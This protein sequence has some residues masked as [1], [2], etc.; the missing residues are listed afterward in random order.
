MKPNHT[1]TWNGKDCDGVRPATGAA[2]AYRCET[3][4]KLCHGKQP[5]YGASLSHCPECLTKL[6]GE[7]FDAV[8]V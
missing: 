4:Q 8:G 3:C 2:I 1:F 6:V 5:N 7:R